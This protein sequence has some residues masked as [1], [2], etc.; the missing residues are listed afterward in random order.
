[1][2]FEEL[3]NEQWSLLAPALLRKPLAGADHGRIVVE[4]AG[5]ISVAVD[6]PMQIRRVAD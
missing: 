6:L 4:A 3:S 5:T 2:V 1:M